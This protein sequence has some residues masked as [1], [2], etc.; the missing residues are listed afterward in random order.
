MFGEL[1]SISSSTFL[2]AFSWHCQQATLDLGHRLSHLLQSG[3]AKAARTTGQDKARFGTLVSPCRSIPVPLV[4]YHTGRRRA[5]N[6]SLENAAVAYVD[7]ATRRIGRFCWGSTRGTANETS[8]IESKG[9]EA[10]RTKLESSCCCCYRMVGK[11]GRVF[12]KLEVPG[13]CHPIR[14]L[15]AIRLGCIGRRTLQALCVHRVPLYRS[16][17][18]ARGVAVAFGNVDEPGSRTQPRYHSSPAVCSRP[19]FAMYEDVGPSTL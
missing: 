7:V 15:Q 4:P 16:R 6:G 8:R 18:S 1:S 3:M 2:D 5:N 9:S 11:N 10:K 13:E 19:D 14:S 17:S 12:H